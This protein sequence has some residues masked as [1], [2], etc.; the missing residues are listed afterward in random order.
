MVWRQIHQLALQGTYPSWSSN[1]SCSTWRPARGPL[2]HPRS[3]S[4]LTSPLTLPPTPDVCRAAQPLTASGADG[5]EQGL[6]AP[7]QRRGRAFTANAPGPPPCTEH[8]TAKLLLALL[9]ESARVQAL[10]ISLSQCGAMRRLFSLRAK[11]HGH[12]N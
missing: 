3:Q 6:W 9:I 11:L 10:V 4:T 1:A 12:A 8:N 7:E 2:T 5:H